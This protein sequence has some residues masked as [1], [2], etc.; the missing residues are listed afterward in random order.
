MR[1][2]N[3]AMSWITA[4]CFLVHLMSVTIPGVPIHTTRSSTFKHILGVILI[5]SRGLI[6]S[7]NGGNV[8]T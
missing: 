8:S 5:L 7:Q 1:V 4:V 2:F 6:K 3:F